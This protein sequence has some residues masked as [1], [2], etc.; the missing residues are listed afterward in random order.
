MHSKQAF[1]HRAIAQ[2]P[3]RCLNTL[4]SIRTTEE[5]NKSETAFVF[6]IHIVEHLLETV[7]RNRQQERNKST[8][9]WLPPAGQ[10]NCLS[11]VGK[12]GRG[13]SSRPLCTLHTPSHRLCVLA[14]QETEAYS[15]HPQTESAVYSYHVLGM[16]E[17]K[18][19]IQLTEGTF[20]FNFSKQSYLFLSYL[21]NLYQ[22]LPFPRNFCFLLLLTNLRFPKLSHVLWK[23]IKSHPVGIPL[24]FRN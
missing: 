2:A 17:G 1:G 14:G 21:W 11:S 5:L 3:V 9:L 19:K 13:E 15:S 20:S 24:M 22:F 18:R 8:L 10:E 6:L 4:L 7:N 23:E 12:Q 16:K